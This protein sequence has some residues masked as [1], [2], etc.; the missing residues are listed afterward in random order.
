VIVRLV[1]IGGIYDHH[2]LKLLSIN[3]Q[4]IL[5]A[6]KMATYVDKIQLH[7]LKLVTCLLSSVLITVS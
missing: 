1:D 4:Y 6:I 2:R 5:I 3:K 7:S